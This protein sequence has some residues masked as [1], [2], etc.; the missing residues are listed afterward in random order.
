M[1]AG[2]PGASQHPVKSYHSFSLHVNVSYVS[3]V[4]SVLTES[5]SSRALQLRG[6][7]ASKRSFVSFCDYFQGK[8]HWTKSSSSSGI[9]VDA[10]DTG[11]GWTPLMRVSAVSGNQSVASVLIEAGADVN[12]KDK[13]GKTPL[14]VCVSAEHGLALRVELRSGCSAIRQFSGI[15][16]CRR[17]VPHWPVNKGVTMS[18]QYFCPFYNYFFKDYQPQ[19]PGPLQHPKQICSNKACT[20]FLCWS[21]L[22][23]LTSP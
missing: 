4:P 17:P 2:C 7:R 1:S 10:V 6:V 19:S 15:R 13:D 16:L 12:M 9:K 11:S 18:L 21:G 20:A 14:M 23:L 8:R 5:Q 22:A 3:T